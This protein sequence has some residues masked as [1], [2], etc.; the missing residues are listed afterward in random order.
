VSKYVEGCD[1]LSINCTFV[2]LSTKFKK[3]VLF[4]Y[5]NV[6]STEEE[7]KHQTTSNNLKA[8]I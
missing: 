5:L 8:S 1:N 4:V 7:K 6:N 2:G 3:N